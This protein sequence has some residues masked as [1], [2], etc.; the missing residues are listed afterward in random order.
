MWLA[1]E[2]YAAHATYLSNCSMEFAFGL[3]NEAIYQG[4]E[5]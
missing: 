2:T 3:V 1:F 4:Q 5:Q